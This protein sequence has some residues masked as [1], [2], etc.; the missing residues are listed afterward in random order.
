[1]HPLLTLGYVYQNQ[2]FGELGGKL[3]FLN[4]DEVLYR[5]GASALVGSVNGNLSVLPKIQ[6]DIL[7]NYQK[8]VDIFHSYYFMTGIE[9][10]TQY[11]APKVGISVFGILDFSGGYAFSLNKNGLHG[12]QLSGLNFNFTLSIPLVAIKDLT[13]K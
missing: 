6:G 11:L 1:M 5:I 3:L 9:A 8:N 4:Q 13:K 12:K 2:N 7:L 10:T